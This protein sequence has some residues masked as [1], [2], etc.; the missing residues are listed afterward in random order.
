MMVSSPS[1]VYMEAIGL[2]QPTDPLIPIVYIMILLILIRTT[3]S[4]RVMV[5]Q[6]AVLQNKALITSA[7]MASVLGPISNPIMLSGI[8]FTFTKEVLASLL[9]SS[10]ILASTAKTILTLLAL[11]FSINAKRSEER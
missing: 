8:S 7:K 3:T 4:L 5:S 6:F 1:G 11:A 2:Q 10:A 9:N